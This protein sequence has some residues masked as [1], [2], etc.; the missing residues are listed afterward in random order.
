MEKLISD[1]IKKQKVASVCCV[2]EAGLPYCFS[3]FFAFNE[4][5]CL[6]FF[7]TNS[8]THH[9]KLLKNNKNIAG[10]IMPDKL[11]VLAIQGIQFQGYVLQANESEQ[12]HAGRH[13]HAKYPFALAMK[14][15]VWTIQLTSIK[16]TDNTKGFGTK[17]NWT[18]DEL[19]F[20][21]N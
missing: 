19:V 13:Y 21:R 12:K 1:F 3:C 4:D 6:L 15:D 5:E 14:G 20:A 17:L 18:K 8:D 2:D 7:K 9:A 11:N 10:T 16:M